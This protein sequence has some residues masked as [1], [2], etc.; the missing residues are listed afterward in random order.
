[1]VYG[2]GLRNGKKDESAW[3]LTRAAIDTQ[4]KRLDET[5]FIKKF[6]AQ[7]PGFNYTYVFGDTYSV[8]G[9]VN[10]CDGPKKTT[11]ELILFWHQKKL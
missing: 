10:G 3:V 8:Q 9:A 7:I 2:C 11:D 5:D 6:E 4:D 1:M